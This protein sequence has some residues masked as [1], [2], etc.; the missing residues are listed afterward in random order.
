M[1]T[2]NK[3][4]SSFLSRC[5]FITC[6]GLRDGKWLLV[7]WIKCVVCRWG[8]REAS[9]KIFVAQGSKAYSIEKALFQDRVRRYLNGTCP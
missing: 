6:S 3:R 1:K 8:L 5:R 4:F 2:F 7:L 9:D